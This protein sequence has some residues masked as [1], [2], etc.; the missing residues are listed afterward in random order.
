[1][2]LIGI[3]DTINL[4][5]FLDPSPQFSFPEVAILFF[6]KHKCYC[7]PS[8]ALHLFFFPLDV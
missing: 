2:L 1:M 7:M 8:T 6:L 4:F 3:Q 5:P